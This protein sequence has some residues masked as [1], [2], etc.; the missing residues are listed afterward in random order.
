M[1]SFSIPE[2]VMPIL[3]RDYE[4][5]STLDIENVGAWR[6]SR[7]A[8]TDVWCCAY[9]IDD[10][11]IEL[12]VPGDPV[13]P[14]FIEA[15]RNPEWLVSAFNDSF[16]R[17]IERHSLGP[18]YSF[19]LVP[20]DR[21][22]CLQAAT[23]ALALPGSL[24]GA[25]QALGLTQQKDEAG[26]RVMLQMARPRKPRAGEDPGGIYWLD[27]PEHRE[28]LYTYCRQD[29]ATARA[30][31]AH[32][33]FL[34]GSEQALWVLDQ[35]I[36][37]RG[38]HVDRALLDAA[39]KIAEQ[40]RAEINAELV[41]ITGGEIDSVHQVGR[42]LEWLNAHGANLKNIGKGALQKA[43]AKGDLPDTTSRVI[44]LRL[45][46][47]HAAADRRRYLALHRSYIRQAGLTARNR[48]EIARPGLAA[49]C[50]HVAGG[51]RPAGRAAG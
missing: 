48:A 11:P 46:G 4:T 45:D 43:L 44:Q 27:D 20:L 8:Q 36:N 51:P 10:G 31:H 2:C 28:Q 6:Y 17:L 34:E 9:C 13:P 21:H 41:K 19:P 30:L 16:E 18:R 5:R 22:R 29:V 42:L 14:Q 37:D 12:W 26:H 32:V 7:H 25:A 49:P 23:L 47:A 50:W 3:I 38:V 33:P 24:S 35:Q 1:P 39:L 15:A 40:G